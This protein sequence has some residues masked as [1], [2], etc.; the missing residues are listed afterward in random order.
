MMG[1]VTDHTDYRKKDKLSSS[2]IVTKCVT[3]SSLYL[4]AGG[5]GDGTGSC[6]RTH[7]ILLAPL[8]RVGLLHSQA[9]GGLP[10]GIAEY[11]VLASERR[12]RYK[13]YKNPTNIQ[14][15]RENK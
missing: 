6:I 1:Q 12:Q 4:G 7:E 14:E 3:C 11:R 9:L 13:L 2:Q 15:K 5:G 10:L 8:V